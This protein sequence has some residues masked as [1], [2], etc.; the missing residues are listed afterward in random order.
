[1]EHVSQVAGGAAVLAQQAGGSQVVTD[2][3]Q[4]VWHGQQATSACYL[5]HVS[6]T[7]GFLAKL[8]QYHQNMTV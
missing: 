8:N 4:A 6:K 7:I 1:M 5:C 3:C 2:V